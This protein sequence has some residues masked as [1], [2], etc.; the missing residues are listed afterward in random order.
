[1]LKYQEWFVIAEEDLRFAKMALRD[2]Q[3]I[4]PAIFHTQQC[5][6]KA[7]KG[8]LVYKQQPLRKIHDLTELIALCQQLDE[9]FFALMDIAA[10]LNPY[11]TKFRYPDSFIMPD[12]AT[13]KVSIDEA[14]QILNFV[15][16]RIACLEKQDVRK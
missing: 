16:E 11:A 1:M 13:L 7:L 12:I 3:C 9:S 2:E 15:K 8:Y 5:A 10:S 14:E 6:E 4:A